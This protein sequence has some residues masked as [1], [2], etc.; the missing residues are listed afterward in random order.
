MCVFNESPTVILSFLLV[1]QFLVHSVG[2]GRAIKGFANI[3]A[4]KL[5]TLM[6]SLTRVSVILLDSLLNGISFSLVNIL[7]VRLIWSF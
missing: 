4:L 1:N 6:W 2:C 5:L 7:L 3:S